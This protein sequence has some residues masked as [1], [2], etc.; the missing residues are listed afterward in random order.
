MVSES[1]SRRA[2]FVWLPLILILA[3][4]GLR[5]LRQQGVLESWPNLSPLMA[6]AFVGAIVFPKPLPWWSWAAMLLGVDL[7]SEGLA[8]WSQAH[9]RMEV[10]GAY[11]CYAMAAF[12]GGR[13]RGRAGVF[14]TLLGTLAC[15]TMFYLATNSIAW[16]VDPA[17]AKTLSG[18]WQA[19][20]WGTGVPG[21]PPTLAFFRNSL[22]ADLGAAAVLLA[23]YNGEALCRRLAGL[24][25]IGRRA[26]A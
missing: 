5:V 2:S 7:L 19:L 24:P 8:W 26:L 17:Y 18:W 22:V 4:L 1:P 11:A 23:V 15:S 6:F 3:A 20:T 14:D 16:W 13:L 10:L 12:W 21:L 9:G 25:W